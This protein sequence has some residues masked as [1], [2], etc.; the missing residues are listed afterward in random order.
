MSEQNQFV[1]PSEN[2]WPDVSD[3][4][5]A[6]RRRSP[7]GK[8]S[9]SQQRKQKINQEVEE[10]KI[11]NKAVEIY[12]DF[13]ASYEWFRIVLPFCHNHSSHCWTAVREVLN[14][15]ESFIGRKLDAEAFVIAAE[16][17]GR[18]PRAQFSTPEGEDKYENL[19]IKVPDFGRVAEVRERWSNHIAQITQK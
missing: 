10:Q 3:L 14:I 4:R 7:L 8:L 17:Q 2:C 1:Y 19:S 6:M 9:P 13:R 11:Q 12:Q 16:A 15:A 18:K 5:I